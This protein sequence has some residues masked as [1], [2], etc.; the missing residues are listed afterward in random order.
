MR[1]KKECLIHKQLRENF[2]YRNYHIVT[3][4]QPFTLLNYVETFFFIQI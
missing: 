3:S 2:I 1:L 4:T